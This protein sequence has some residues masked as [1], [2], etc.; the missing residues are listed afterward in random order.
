MLIKPPNN[1]TDSEE[2]T[3]YSVIVFDHDGRQIESKILENF[4]KAADFVNEQTNL[5]YD[6]HLSQI[7]RVNK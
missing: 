1:E 5:G 2:P 4:P 7:K 3:K 6:T